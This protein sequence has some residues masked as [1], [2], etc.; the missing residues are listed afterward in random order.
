[1]AGM[2]RLFPNVLSRAFVR[3]C[4][5]RLDTCMSII[6]SDDERAYRCV[7]S[8]LQPSNLDKNKGPKDLIAHRQGSEQNYPTTYR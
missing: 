2:A 1:M 8:P 6:Q 3:H 7:E 4:F 5:H